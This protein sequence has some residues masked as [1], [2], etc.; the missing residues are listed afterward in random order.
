MINQ[1]SIGV[2]IRGDE[3]LEAVRSSDYAIGEF[4]IL[5][6]LIF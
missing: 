3:G 5:R 1:G 4:K 6:K 2:G